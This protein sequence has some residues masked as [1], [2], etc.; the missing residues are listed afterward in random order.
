MTT[1]YRNYGL[2]VEAI[3]LERNI[4]N[5]SELARDFDPKK[6]PKYLLDEIEQLKRQLNSL[7]SIRAA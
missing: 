5:L 1:T 3:R 4:R 6:R 2:A 7:R